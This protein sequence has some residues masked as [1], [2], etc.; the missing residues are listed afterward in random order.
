MLLLIALAAFGV[1]LSIGICG[2]AGFLLPVF[3]LGCC[4]FTSDESLFL[5]FGC[6]LISGALGAL[7]YR[8]KGELPAKAALPLGLS[9]LCGSLAGAMI[10]RSFLA[11]HAKTVLYAVVL[12]SGAAILLQEL[13][14]KARP[15]AGKA[16]GAEILILLGF[17]T[18]AVC[19]L[20]GA[21]GP[22]LVMPLLVLFGMGVRA[23]VGTALFDSVFIA[24]PALFVYGARGL[25]GR[26]V[27]PM[28][29]AFLLH[30][31]G[32]W[33][34]AGVA[35]RVPQKPLKRGIAV[36]SVLFSLYMLFRP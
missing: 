4:G 25:T 6:F 8:Q 15:D 32:I 24:V 2:V 36:F 22:V 34:G 27:L 18:A 11:I 9:S 17:L 23:A 19:A 3:F 26:I 35:D 28:A 21:G 1:G 31:L 16:P 29:A 33:L 14:G 12:L 7:R 30:A 20:S 13:P 10:G 5:S